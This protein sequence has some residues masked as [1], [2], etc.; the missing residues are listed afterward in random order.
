MDAVV[1]VQVAVILAVLAAAWV[2]LDWD[3]YG[4]RARR[5]RRRFAPAE[6]PVPS[7][8]PIERIAADLR[9]IRSA[10]RHASPGTP[11]ARMRGW[12]AAYDDVLVAACRALDLEQSLESSSLTAVERE[13]ERERVERML[14]RTGLLTDHD[15]EH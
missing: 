10:I 14:A 1:W 5:L 4:E 3:A 7:G 12:R 2:L 6:P 8:P 15:V 13:L 11:V 9:R